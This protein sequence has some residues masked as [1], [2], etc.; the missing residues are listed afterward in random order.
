MGGLG[1][2]IMECAPRRGIYITG[3]REGNGNKFSS[4]YDEERFELPTEIIQKAFKDAVL[5]L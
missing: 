4:R 3:E 2:E 5:K 1:N